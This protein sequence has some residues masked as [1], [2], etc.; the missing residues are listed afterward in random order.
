[1]ISSKIQEA[2]KSAILGGGVGGLLKGA[3]LAYN[4][5]KAKQAPTI[6]SATA[7]A[8]IAKAEKVEP[9][10]GA[11]IAQRAQKDSATASA[12]ETLFKDVSTQ[13]PHTT[14]TQTRPLNL[15]EWAESKAKQERAGRSAV[16][17]KQTV[18]DAFP[19]APPSTIGRERLGEII[20]Q[21]DDVSKLET[22]TLLNIIA[23]GAR[24][25]AKGSLIGSVGG[26]ASGGYNDYSGDGKLDYK[27]VGIGALLGMIGG[28]AVSKMAQNGTV[29]SGHIGI[30][31]SPQ[32]TPLPKPPLP[33]STGPQ[34]TGEIKGRFEKLKER[35]SDE[36]YAG[37]ASNAIDGL[38]RHKIYKDDVY[39]GA[40]DKL[41]KRLAGDDVKSLIDY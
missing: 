11:D 33:K 17:E 19:Y 22:K 37:K 28:G 36:I 39:M 13:K 27:D 26:G 2:G 3:G 20:P 8:D 38:F 40:R 4:A 7:S 32:G 1:M 34:G 25:H 10:I 6:E 9:T 31:E 29:R 14:Q 41:N 18:R 24:E 12:I 30:K 16:A 21:A 23:N 35:V 15:F 5:Y